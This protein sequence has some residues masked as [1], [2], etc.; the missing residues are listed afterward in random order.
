ML[1]SCVVWSL[2]WW[3]EEDV[4]VVG[5]LAF[6]RPG[7]ADLSG[8][9]QLG[10]SSQSHLSTELEE[11]QGCIAGPASAMAHQPGRAGFAK[12]PTAHGAPPPAK[13]TVDHF[14]MHPIRQFGSG[15]NGNGLKTVGEGWG[16]VFFSFWRSASCSKEISVQREKS[17]ATH[18]C[19]ATPLTSYP[20]HQ[21]GWLA[22]TKNE[23]KGNFT[24]IP[25]PPTP[26]SVAR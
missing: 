4:C 6:E 14:T 17:K 22:H 7:G 24:S 8:S 21:R 1:G 11:S 16:D 23:K 18:Q 10:S 20:F 25:F 19:P 5:M 26:A 13:R 12:C 3:T 9:G 15:A 2:W